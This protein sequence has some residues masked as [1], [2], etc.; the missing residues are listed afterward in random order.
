MV[1]A[2]ISG[3]VRRSLMAMKVILVGDVF[4]SLEDIVTPEERD[5]G[6]KTVVAEDAPGR[7]YRRAWYV[8]DPGKS[9]LYRYN[10]ILFRRK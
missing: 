7:K 6:Q 5:L 3:K 9:E 10:P 8:R 2:G 1:D 4:T